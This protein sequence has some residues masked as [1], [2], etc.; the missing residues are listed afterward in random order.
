MQGLID[1]HVHLEQLPDI[2]ASLAR[3]QQAGLKALIAV[4]QDQL[5]NESLFKFY[6]QSLKIEPKIYLALGIHPGN[7]ENLELAGAL[8]FI[9][10]GREHLV[11]IGEIGL[12]YWYPQARKDGPPRKRQQEVF[13]AQLD[14]AVRLGLP[15]I[16]HSRGAW[17]DCLRFLIERKVERGLFH[18]YSGPQDVLAEI[19]NRGYIISAA[20]SAEY[21]KDHQLAISNT[22]LDKIILETDSPVKYRPPS[23]DYDSEPKDIWRTLEA[24]AKIKNLPVDQVREETARNAEQ[25]FGLRG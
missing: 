18:W 19:I 8:R 7:L 20:P 16:V 2:E 25:F 23:G 14:L 13:A 17:S 9:E 3:A 1:T 6:L 22:P 21:S 24:V 10:Q 5:A 15:A 4:G 12:D 11:A